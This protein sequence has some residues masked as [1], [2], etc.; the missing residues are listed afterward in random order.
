MTVAESVSAATQCPCHRFSNTKSIYE[1]LTSGTSTNEVIDWLSG[2]HAEE[3]IQK[4]GRLRLS[5][6]SSD[7]CGNRVNTSF[8]IL[9]DIRSA[10]RDY[11]EGPNQTTLEE[12]RVTYETSFP[13]LSQTTPAKAP[14]AKPNI[15]VTRKNPKAK[16]YQTDSAPELQQRRPIR[17]IR[18]AIAP[19]PSDK[20]NIANLQCEP[21]VRNALP[22]SIDSSPL[23]RSSSTTMQR[24]KK[25]VYH[26]KH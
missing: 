16:K 12:S 6:N 9:N 13:S 19:S 17:R 23:E 15:L 22:A 3:N 24:V 10:C 20:G 2:R 25:G 8:S 11:L 1:A 18:P 21:L 5:C 14:A 7:R 4:Q 26:P